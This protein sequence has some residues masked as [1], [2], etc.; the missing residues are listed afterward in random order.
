[1][2]GRKIESLLIHF[3]AGQCFV[4]TKLVLHFASEPE[5]P[6]EVSVHLAALVVLFRHSVEPLN[7]LPGLHSLKPC[8]ETERTYWTSPDPVLGRR[9]LSRPCSSASADP[10][11]HLPFS[12][13][14]P[15][16]TQAAAA[17]EQIIHGLHHHA[18]DLRQSHFFHALCTP[19]PSPSQSS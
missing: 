19:P 5:P 17:F 2:R 10:M 8:R 6:R 12:L 7:F 16:S 13:R 1:M 15:R 4:C 18:L 3:C 9:R 11:T 14:S